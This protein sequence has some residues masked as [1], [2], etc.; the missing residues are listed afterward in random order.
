MVSLHSFELLCSKTSIA[1]YYKGI[2]KKT[3]RNECEDNI[4]VKA[5]NHMQYKE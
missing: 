3:P 1:G 2:S 5:Y 4:S